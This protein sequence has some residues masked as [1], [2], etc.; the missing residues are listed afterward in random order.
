MGRR[1]VR[2]RPHRR[3][4]R[5]P[6][7]RRRADADQPRPH[8]R[9]EPR[10]R[11]QAHRRPRP[12]GTRT[13]RC[14]CGCCSAATTTSPTST[15]SRASSATAT[16]CAAT[17]SPTWSTTPRSR[18]ALGAETID[19]AADRAGPARARGRRL[20]QRHR[21]HRRARRRERGARL[22]PVVVG[23]PAAARRR[24]RRRT[25]SAHRPRGRS[26]RSADEPVAVDP[27]ELRYAPRPPSRLALDPARRWRSSRCSRSSSLGAVVGYRWTQD[28]YFV[29]DHEGHVTIY[30][31]VMADIPGVTLQHVEQATDIAMDSLPEFRRQQVDA[32][33]EASSRADAD[34]IVAELEELPNRA[35]ARRRR[36]TPPRDVR[37]AVQGHDRRSGDEQPADLGASQA[38]GRRVLPH[39]PR[40]AHRHRGLLRRRAR[41]QG[42]DPGRRRQA[43]R[44]AHRA[45]RH[46]P[47]RRA[48]RRPVRRPGA[49]AA[50]HLPQ[51]PRA[52]DDLPARPRP[53]PDRPGAAGVR[54]LPADLDGH[55]HRRVRRRPVRRA[56]PPPAADAHLHVRVRRH[57]AADPAAAAGHRSHHQ[58]RA[59]LDQ[60]RPVQLPARRGGQDLPGDLLRRLPGGQARRPRPG[61]A[62]HRRHRPPAR[63]RPR[64]DPRGLAGQRRHPGVPA[65]PRLVAAVLRPVRGDALRRHRARRLAGRR[66]RA[67]RRRRVLRLPRPSATCRSRFDAWLD[68]FGDPD[69]N[70]QIINGLFGL[71]HGGILGT[72]L[73]PGQPAADARS[74]SPT[75]S[76]PRW[77]RSSGS[78][79]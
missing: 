51:R 32:G 26:R 75:S 27:E 31:G 77:A 7:A 28:Q 1:A 13:A 17:A 68:P 29:A 60:P 25:A 47:P 39:H 34:R 52:G 57:R 10:R 53:Q 71:A 5:L 19:M 56:R 69:R 72:R 44:R 42:H 35:D 73:G 62:P 78:P 43:G 76:P 11:G 36:P 50:G 18:E 3:L 45:R 67:V 30:R 65:R 74:R 2:D 16:C 14:C 22:A 6:P 79:G 8:V 70:G 9:P 64:P 59:H 37:R 20:R 55:R 38:T 58:R 66:R 40:G 63:P 15:T 12:A 61:R 46:R 24:R 23:R 21:R 4:A 41:H 48:P 33:I 54:Q 49:A